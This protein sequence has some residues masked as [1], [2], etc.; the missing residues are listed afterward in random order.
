MWQ[1]QLKNLQKRRF[2]ASNFSRNNI[3][4]FNA[5]YA[6]TIWNNKRTGS[7]NFKLD[8]R[9]LGATVGIRCTYPSTVLCHAIE[10]ANDEQSLCS[11]ICSLTVNLLKLILNIQS[12]RKAHLFWISKWHELK[13]RETTKMRWIC[14]I[15]YHLLINSGIN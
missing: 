12:K 13:N 5:F 4:Y 9:F 1:N 6:V 2:L 7:I 14:F 15:M 11:G 10:I 8:N 3:L